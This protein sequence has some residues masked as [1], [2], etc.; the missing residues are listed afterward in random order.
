MKITVLK[1]TTFF[2]NIQLI[3]ATSKIEF[4]LC[5]T[6]TVLRR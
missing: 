5:W 6:V 3:G 2:F 1:T 4:Y